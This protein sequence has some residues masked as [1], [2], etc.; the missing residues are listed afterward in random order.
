MTSTILPLQHM[1]TRPPPAP[2][3][4][5]TLLKNAKLPVAYNTWQC[6]PRKRQCRYASGPDFRDNMNW[7]CRKNAQFTPSP[8]E[9]FEIEKN[10]VY[11]KRKYYELAKIYHPDRP[12]DKL[13]HAER[14]E[15]YRLIVQAHE[16]LSDPVKRRAYDSSGAGWGTRIA[17]DRHS[18]GFHN[19]EGKRYGF[20]PD[21]DSSVFA[22]AT[23]E[24]WERW[25]RRN[26]PKPKYQSWVDPNMF[27]TSIIFI[28]ILAGVFQATRTGQYT[29]SIEERAQEFTEKTHRFLS[30]R[31]DEQSEMQGHGRV[32]HFL[33]QR[34]PARYGLKEEEEEA[35]RRHFAS[36]Q[37]DPNLKGSV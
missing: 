8:Y 22:N 13:T 17:A 26:D 30:D 35:Y 24:D 25:Y 36:L 1:L 9:I 19:A 11:N 21:D 14:L 4:P 34:D 18:R 2:S 3:M 6:R 5:P 27:A 32:K 37:P 10:A 7:P 16:I 28:A 33:Q 23:W 20:G 29:G 12:N 31:R 15:R